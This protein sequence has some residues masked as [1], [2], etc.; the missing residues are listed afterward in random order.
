PRRDGEDVELVRSGHRDEEVDRVVVSGVAIDDD[1]LQRHHD[2]PAIS[3]N[4]CRGSKR[5]T[6]PMINDSIWAKAPPSA[7]RSA[8]ALPGRRRARRCARA[9]PP[10]HDARERFRREPAT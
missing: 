6:A 3:G 8:E 2:G 5:S 7:M 9:I 10:P 4:A 1:G